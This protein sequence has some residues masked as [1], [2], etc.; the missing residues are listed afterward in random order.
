VTAGTYAYVV[1][2]E[3]GLHII[4][5]SDPNSPVIAGSVD[6]SGE[7]RDIALVGST[8]YVA[9][10]L[11][12]L[13]V[14]DVANKSTPKII[15]TFNTPLGYPTPTSFTSVTVAGDY[16]WVTAGYLLSLKAQCK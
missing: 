4:D 5:I 9:D 14:I 16:V 8:L 15:G 11:A 12:G 3:A 2:S 1:T 6:T 7:A 13:L 10:G